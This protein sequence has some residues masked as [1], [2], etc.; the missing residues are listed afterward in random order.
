MEEGKTIISFPLPC[1]ETPWTDVSPSMSIFTFFFFTSFPRGFF[2]T[3]P[4][5]EDLVQSSYWTCYSL[6]VSRLRGGREELDG[7][8]FSCTRRPIPMS[9]DSLACSIMSMD[10]LLGMDHTIVANTRGF[11]CDWPH[12]SLGPDCHNSSRT[13]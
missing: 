6:H 5:G 11:R 3:S 4:G 13:G 10:E 9:S 12:Q 2:D 8:R 1:R 7:F